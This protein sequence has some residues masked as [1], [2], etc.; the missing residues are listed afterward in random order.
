MKTIIL[1]GGKG[2]RLGGRADY[3][4]KAMT[5]IGHRPIVWHIMKRYSLAGYGD[6]ILALGEKGELLRDFFIHYDYFTSDV[7]VDLSKGKIDK[8]SDHQ[9]K[10]WEIT[11]VDTGDQAQSGARIARCKKYLDDKLF[12]VSYSDCLANINIKELIKFHRKT[13]KVATITGVI[14]PYREGEFSVENNLVLG[15]YDAK[16]ERKRSRQR[17]IN[18]GFF[19]FE[20]AI[21]N[22]LSSF[23]ECR[24]ESEV[25]VQL[26]KEQQLAVFPHYG[27]WQWLDTDRD[28]AYL[29][30]LVDRNNM[31]WLEE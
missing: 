4:P 15:M 21:F 16:Q 29:N 20:Q 2:T 1:C 18:G 14:P 19:V 13:K 31:Y 30:Q 3:V 5:K 24:L 17:Y 28:H 7:R 12:M 26:I 27:F 22:Y 9:E 10:S 8:L 6:F 25:F 11:L 23:S